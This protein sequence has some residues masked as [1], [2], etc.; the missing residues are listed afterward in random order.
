MLD[1]VQKNI[2]NT[3]VNRHGMVASIDMSPAESDW[4]MTEAQFLRRVDKVIARRDMTSVVI[5]N[6]V[7]DI[8]LTKGGKAGRFKW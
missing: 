1:M 6:E 5:V 8:L 2:F 3:L 4:M 7:T